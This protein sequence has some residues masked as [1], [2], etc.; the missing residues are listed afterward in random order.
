MFYSSQVEVENARQINNINQY[1]KTYRFVIYA[2]NSI[3]I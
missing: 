3:Y 2:I 1:V